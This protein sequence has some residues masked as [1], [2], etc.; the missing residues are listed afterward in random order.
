MPGRHFLQIPGPSNIPN[1]VLK[2]MDRPV[3]N[4]RGETFGE[5]TKG[6][7]PK[8]K[9]V[10]R[11]EQG[12]PLV[13]PSS[14]TGAW[15]ASLVNTLSPGDSVLAFIIGFFSQEYAQTAE[16]LG[17]KVD[18][19]Q[20][21]WGS[22]IP[23]DRVFEELSKDKAHRYKAVLTIHNETSTGVMTNLRA[24]REAIDRAG[25]PA[26]LLVD[27]VSGLGSIDLRMDE[28][29]LDV[30][31]TCSQ[32]GLLLPPGLG[33]LAVSR[34]ALEA[35]E[36]SKTPRHYFDWGGMLERN[37]SG[38]FPYT[39]A[40]Q[41]LFGLDEALDML[42]EEGLEQVFARHARLAEGVRRAVKAWGLT[43]LAE[44]PEEASNVLATVMLPEGA[45][46]NALIAHT[47]GKLDLALGNGLG[48][49][50]GRAFRIGHLG[51]INELEVLGTLAGVELGLH[52][53]GVK[54]PL[55]SGVAAC[56]DWF[57][58]G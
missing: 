56:Q 23:G 5:L 15:E 44:R 53:M 41:L 36:G 51:S 47:E 57:L 6:I 32:K 28:W 45:D 48:Q 31:V 1:R 19:V 10:F 34:K 42:L 58:N 33:L 9:Q 14:G 43:L 40:S 3:I 4:H 37:P 46:S 8:L 22:G 11:T 30:V 55:G 27:S 18:R 7:F 20:L 54:V 13:F 25:H 2:A 17:F 12:T 50:N 26:L 29:G 21:P 16:D 35:Y 24:I 49:L 38:F 39:P 52:A